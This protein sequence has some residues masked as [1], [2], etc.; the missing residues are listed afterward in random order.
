MSWTRDQ[1]HATQ[2]QDSDILQNIPLS[3]G[4]VMFFSRQAFVIS[5]SRKLLMMRPY[6]KQTKDKK[7]R[8]KWI[9]FPLFVS[10]RSSGPRCQ[11]EL[12]DLLPSKVL[13]LSEDRFIWAIHKKIEIVIASWSFKKLTLRNFPFF[14]YNFMLSHSKAE[15][16]SLCHL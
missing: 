7:K 9:Q 5:V 4:S 3:T 16:F 1:K 6:K 12:S 11:A 15:N 10:S 13:T 14:F 8:K 2:R